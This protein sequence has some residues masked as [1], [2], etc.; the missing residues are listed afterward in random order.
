MNIISKIDN[1]LLLCEANK[2]DSFIEWLVTAD[3]LLQESPFKKTFEAYIKHIMNKK[4]NICSFNF[5]YL[6]DNFDL[7]TSEGNIV[8]QII[9]GMR[10]DLANLKE[11]TYEY[12]E[13]EFYSQESAF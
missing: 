4:L 2:E 1:Y 11:G 3:K 13:D 6:K 12:N 9:Q 7:K 10:E 5:F 8:Y